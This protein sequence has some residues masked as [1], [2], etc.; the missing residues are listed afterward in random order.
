MSDIVTSSREIPST[1]FYV[2]ATD[3][4]MS[5]WGPAEGTDN[6]CVFPCAT[7]TEAQHVYDECDRR[8]EMIRVR[9]TGAK[10][11]LRSHWTVSL[12]DRSASA[13]YPTTTEDGE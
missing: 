3:K 9:I 5:G 8:T 13:F 11:R 10:P 12:F 2:L 4:F 1:R 7:L 6:V